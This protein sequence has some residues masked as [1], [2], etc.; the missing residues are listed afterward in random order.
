VQKNPSTSSEPYPTDRDF[1]Q[2]KLQSESQPDRRDYSD[3]ARSRPRLRKRF[4]EA[5]YSSSK[6][7]R[8]YV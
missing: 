5:D 3:N 4:Q 6:H 7:T 1:L 2:Q 8:G